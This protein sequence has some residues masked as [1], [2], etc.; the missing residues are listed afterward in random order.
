MERGA[1]PQHGDSWQEEESVREAEEARLS[2]SRTESKLHLDSQA[3]LS[4]NCL[5]SLQNHSGSEPNILNPGGSVCIPA[6]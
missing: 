4:L 3:Y 1:V 5:A 6:L 2:P